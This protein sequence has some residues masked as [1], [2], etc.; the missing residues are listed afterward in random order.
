MTAKLIIASGSDANMRYATGLTI[1]DPFIYVKLGKKACVLVSS[2]E[3]AFAKSNAKPG[4]KVILID[5]LDL[6]ALKKQ[7]GRK[8]NY[9][10]IA[11]VFLLSYNQTEVCI[12]DDF[13]AL[14]LD[15]LREHGLRV[16]IEVPFYPERIQ[17]NL[18]EIK[19]IKYTGMITKQAM[20]R[21]ITIIK[22]S[23]IDWDETLLWNDA[24]LTSEIVKFEI[25]KIFLENSCI[26]GET[27]VSC[28]EQASE[29]HN[30]GSGKLFA[31]QPIVMDI[32]PKSLK[33]GYYFDMTRTV[34]KGTPSNDLKKLYKTVEDAQ[35]AGIK[36]IKAGRKACEVHQACE[37][38]MKK[39]GYKTTDSEGFIH[40]T[41]HG[42]GL[43]IHEDPNIGPRNETILQPGMVITVEPGLYYKDIGGVRIEDTVLV[44]AKGCTNL[45]NFPKVSFLK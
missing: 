8:R 38:V 14:H 25:E 20:Q 2:L 29:P 6:S 26:S 41:G 13:W 39:A 43:E 44:T 18:E 34:V 9:A 16:K 21:A 24:P 4:I 32:F 10:D 3:Y 33:T 17:K 19:A 40:S 36:A 37:A 35:L 12:P 5:K 23:T 31:G 1:P 45:T 30:R 22:D 11:A 7:V 27:I 28:G 42:L 15:T